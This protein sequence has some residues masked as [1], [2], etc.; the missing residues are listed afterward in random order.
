LKHIKRGEDDDDPTTFY[1]NIHLDWL[2]NVAKVV[3]KRLDA[4]VEK[5]RLVQLKV[6]IFFLYF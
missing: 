4:E 2:D 1:A 3:N 6:C 5:E